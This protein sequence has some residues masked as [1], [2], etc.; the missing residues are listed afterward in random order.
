MWQKRRDIGLVILVGVTG[1]LGIQSPNY[2]KAIPLSSE[3]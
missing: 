2:P 1:N 3:F